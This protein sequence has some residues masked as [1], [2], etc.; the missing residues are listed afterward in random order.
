MCAEFN[1]KAHNQSVT[2]QLE[3]F[4]VNGRNKTRLIQLLTHKMAA[5]GI[6]TRFSTGDADTYIMRCGLEKAISHPIVVRRGQDVDIVV[7]LVALAPPENDI[8]FMK[9]GKRKVED[10][11]FSTR[12]LKKELSTPKHLP[13]PCIQLLRHNTSYL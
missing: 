2:I 5:K 10:K 13:S 11:L 4:L 12:K 6:E 3:H 7:L 9:T 1:L 8:Y